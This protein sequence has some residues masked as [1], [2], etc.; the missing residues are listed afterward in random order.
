MSIV[1]CWKI[2]I[3]SC[4]PFHQKIGLVFSNHFRKI[5]WALL[6]YCYYYYYYLLLLLTKILTWHL[7]KKTAR[8]RKKLNPVCRHLYHVVVNKYN[9]KWIQWILHVQLQSVFLSITKINKTNRSNEVWLQTLNK[10]LLAAFATWF[11][12]RSPADRLA[13]DTP[14]A[15]VGLSRGAT[16]AAWLDGPAM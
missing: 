8:T 4:K 6:Y 15:G 12:R 1:A 7:V 10:M 16:A 2:S 3:R 13:S 14:R 11:L 5:K 9:E